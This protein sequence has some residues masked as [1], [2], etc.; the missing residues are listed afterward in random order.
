MKD[1]IE[2]RIAELKEQRDQFVQQA[3]QQVA[4]LNGAIQELERLLNPPKESPSQ[5]PPPQGGDLQ[6]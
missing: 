2:R 3:N 4:A 6:V 5:L 1:T